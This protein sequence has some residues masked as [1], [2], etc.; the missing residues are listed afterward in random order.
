LYLFDHDAV[1]RFIVTSGRDEAMK[2]ID[3]AVSEYPDL[4]Y[5]LR[6]HVIID[7]NGEGGLIP[8]TP[9]VYADEGLADSA[10]MRLIDDA[11]EKLSQEWSEPL[12]DVRNQLAED[13]PAGWNPY[14]EGVFFVEDAYEYRRWSVEVR[15]RPN[16]RR[17]GEELIASLHP[18]V[19][20][21][22]CAEVYT[23]CDAG[24]HY[25]PSCGQNSEE[26]V[27]VTA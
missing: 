18:E 19:R 15:L 7:S 26:A 21:T 16:S 27:E 4:V 25:C 13:H 20:C 9:D 5:P 14:Q 6:V 11:L 24:N 23:A 17:W 8:G 1:R 12:E 22:E 3:A 2:L 10:W